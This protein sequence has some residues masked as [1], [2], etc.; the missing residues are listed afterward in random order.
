MIYPS[1][2]RE[3][4]LCAFP[5]GAIAVDPPHDVQL[6]CGDLGLSA[7]A[8]RCADRQ[9]GEKAGRARRQQEQA[10]A[11]AYRVE[12]A[13]HNPQSEVS[14]IAS[15]HVNMCSPNGTVL[16][17]GS[18]QSDRWKELF[19]GGAVQFEKGYAL[20]PDRPGFTAR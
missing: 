6:D 14:T 3:Y 16:E 15:L 19:Y 12:M 18:G 9:L 7:R 2:G 13:P 20:A 5:R 1:I 11:E 17:I 4:C 10:V 8:A